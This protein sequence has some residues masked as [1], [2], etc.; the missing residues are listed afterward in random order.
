MHKQMLSVLAASALLALNS[1]AAIDSNWTYRPV[2]KSV[3]ASDDP[4]VQKFHPLATP[5]SQRLM[6]Q[7][8]DRLAICGDSITEQKMYS[9]IIEDY[10]TVCAPE[11]KVTVRQY[12]WSGEKAPGFL[13]RMTNDCLRFKPTIATTCYGMNDHEYRTYEDRI[14]KTYEDSSRAIVEAFKANGTRVILGSPGCI[15]KVPFWTKT[16]NATVDDLNVNLCHLRNIDVQLAEQEKVAFADVFWPMLTIGRAARELYGANYNISG[17]DGV[18]PNWAGH[19]VM[20]FAFLKAMGVS[21]EIGIFHIN[22]K[23]NKLTTSKGHEVVS[24]KDGKFT[25]RSFKYPFCAC[26]PADADA[27]KYPSC[28]K[29][30]PT[31]D[32]SISSVLSFL[33]FDAQLNRMALTVRDAS[34]TNQYSVTWENESKTFPGAQLR[35]GIDLLREFKQNPFSAAFAKVDA[36]VA[37]KQAFETKEIKQLFRSPEAK[38]NMEEVVTKA[39]AERAP[40]AE[41]IAKAFV[42]VEHTITIKKL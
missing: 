21:G 36:A 20:A 24:A 19:T 34:R 33:R 31:K 22:L 7:T 23:Q 12:G 5:F 28:D 2:L 26:E 32:D 27:A 35:T 18:H 30:D 38:A 15:G 25:I 4:L 1:A 29:D 42:P 9:R 6:L 41:A 39:E 37:A 3:A 10:L 17:A 11:L 8:N 40:L 16:T 14:G 13:A